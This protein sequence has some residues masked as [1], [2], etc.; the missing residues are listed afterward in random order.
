MEN[1]TATFEECE[2]FVKQ[3]GEPAVKSGKQEKLE[4]MLNFYVR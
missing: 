2:E 1:G 3:N 4:N